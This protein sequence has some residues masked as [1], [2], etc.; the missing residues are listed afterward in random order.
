MTG[1]IASASFDFMRR[2]S[3][4]EFAQVGNHWLKHI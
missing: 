2:I 3:A 1:G 4:P